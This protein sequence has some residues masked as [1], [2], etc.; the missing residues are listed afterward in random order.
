MSVYNNLLDTLSKEPVWS[1]EQ[2]QAI[3]EPFKYSSAS[4]GKDIRRKLVEAFN[5]WLEVPRDKLEVIANAVNMFHAASLM[6][7]DIEDNSQLRRGHPVAHKIYGIPQTINTANYVYFMAYRELL[8]I[9]A[10]TTLTPP[11]S[12]EALATAELLSLHRGQGL[13]I[14]WRDSLHCP[15]EEEYIAMV[16]NKT[17]GLLRL[18]IKLM[19]ACCTRNIGRDYIPLVNLFGVFFQIRDDFLNLQS[20]EYTCKKGFAEDLSEG[21]FSFPIIHGIQT[22][23]ANR[24]VLNIL[25]KRP[26]T[27]TLKIHA[28]D[29]LRDCTKSFDYTLS[30]LTVLEA[31]TR[32]EIGRLGGNE[33]LEAIMD[34]LH[35][36]TS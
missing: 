31:Q 18:A 27:P 16:N 13:D 32:A 3:L 29:Y 35:V 2:D 36:G 8:T 28:I 11:Q 4:P 12:L 20:S 1:Q 30:V 6:V 26:T 7:D 19:M 34:A 33:G 9:R 17:G 5:D 23:K 25:Q 14:L 22:D 15:S 10:G 21:K 24:Q